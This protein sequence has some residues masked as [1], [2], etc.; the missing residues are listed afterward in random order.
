MEKTLKQLVLATILGVM[1]LLLVSGCEK[2]Q[3]T[4]DVV[5]NTIVKEEPVV[6][7][8]PVSRISQVYVTAYGPEGYDNSEF[9]VGANSRIVFTN[10]NTKEKGF[11]LGSFNE[12]Y[13]NRGV[14]LIKQ[15]P[16]DGVNLRSP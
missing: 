16:L 11:S 3:I 10:K 2:D 9:K 12:Q 14:I 4:G 8:E 6:E 1:M 7:Q 13:L 5:G 15:N